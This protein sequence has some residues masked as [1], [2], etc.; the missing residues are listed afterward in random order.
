MKEH[1]KVVSVFERFQIGDVVEETH[2][3]NQRFGEIDIV[4][5]NKEVLKDIVEWI[6]ETLEILDEKMEDM[7]VSRLDSSAYQK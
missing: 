7:Q 5:E 6:Y 2:N 1:P 3:V 4:C